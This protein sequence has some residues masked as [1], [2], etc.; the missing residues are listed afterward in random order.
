MGIRFN[1]D[2]IFEIALQIERNGSAFYLRAA[3]IMKDDKSRDLL[4]GFARWE[5]E[6]ERVF[7]AMRA[8]LSGPDLEP[9]VFDP[10]GEAE[11]YLRALAD[12]KV[13]DLRGNPAAKLTGSE[14][15]EEVLKNALNREKEAVIFYVGMREMVPERLGKDKIDVIVK[16]EMSHIRILSN[17][18][19]ALRQ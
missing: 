14:T 6:H 18:L 8:Q 19:A 13:F 3:G 4:M 7:A 1:A 9:T 5:Q 15:Y 2:E 10:E 16:E 12:S 17:E 11:I